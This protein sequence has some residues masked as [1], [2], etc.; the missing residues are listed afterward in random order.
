MHPTHDNFGP[1]KQQEGAGIQERLESMQFEERP[2]GK[3]KKDLYY[4]I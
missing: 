4:K 3:Q 1:V 2:T